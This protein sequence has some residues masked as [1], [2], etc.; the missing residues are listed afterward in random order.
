MP[1]PKQARDLQRKDQIVLQ[2]VTIGIDARYRVGTHLDAAVLT[3]DK[4]AIHGKADILYRYYNGVFG[5]QGNVL[6]RFEVSIYIYTPPASA[7]NCG[8][9]L[10]GSS[11][12]SAGLQEYD[13]PDA[14]LLADVPSMVLSL[15]YCSVCTSLWGRYRGYDLYS[16]TVLASVWMGNQ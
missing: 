2:Q 16:I 14:E 3:N 1:V 12:Y 4:V 10:A 8:V 11:R 7:V 13:I 5:K 15:T 9:G 6:I